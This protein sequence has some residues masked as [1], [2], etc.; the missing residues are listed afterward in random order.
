MALG[1]GAALVALRPSRLAP[2]A[3]VHVIGFGASC[4]AVHLTAP[5][6]TGSG[7]AAA[8]RTAL[9]EA[10][11]SLVDLVSP[12]GSATSF[13]DAAESRALRAA[14]PGSAD[15]VVLHPFKAQVGHTLGASGVL[16]TLACVD[17]LVRGV[18]PAAAGE[19]DIDPDAPARLLP[20]TVRASPAS[21][22]KLSAAFGG[23]NAALVLSK[24][25]TAGSARSARPVF[26]RR[27]YHLATPPLPAD[28]A[29]R[30]AWPI[31]RVVRADAL[32]RS[33]LAAVAALVERD[34]PL[35]PAG[36]IVGT[37]FATLETD[38]SF[39][40]RILERGARMA[41]PRKFPYTSPN[42]AAGDA[43]VAFGLTGPGFSV[44]S[45][46][47]AGVEALVVACQLVAAGDAE[48][49]V[50]VGVDEVGPVASGL[51]D[52]LDMRG[53]TGAVSV[54]VSASR[55]KAAFEVTSARCG[56]GGRGGGKGRGHEALVP[57][58]GLGALETVE[59]WSPD[60]VA[61][62]G[63]GGVGR[64]IAWARVDLR[65]IDEAGR[66]P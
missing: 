43:G 44:G 29:A 61:G 7:L 26:V 40:A 31:D 14:L 66:A 3:L 56:L 50:V 62:A 34:G 35:A 42:A 49:M 9:R 51:R 11:L 30:I 25:P 33:V 28:L 36:I 53:T 16:E 21:A 41:E 13:S 5:D 24:H 1:E 47:H 32:T 4:D 17:A 15:E 6:R 46:E 54:V 19:G 18:L 59:A 52:A 58:A 27:G 20:L 23:A 38:A 45:G 22:L 39:F 57:L 60:P 55:E 12:H 63:V 64:G 65:S 2:D 8:A 10:G 37:T 48:T